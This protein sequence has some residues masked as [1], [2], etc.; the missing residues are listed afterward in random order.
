MLGLADGD[1]GGVVDGSAGLDALSPRDRDAAGEDEGFGPGARLGE[2]ALDEE[3]V[4][5]LFLQIVTIT[6]RTSPP[7]RASRKASAASASGTRCV[8]RPAART[9]PRSMSASASR[10][11]R[12]VEE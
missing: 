11:S 10:R 8:T 6:F 1:L 9:T 12:S 4:E 2:A 7:P 3:D 5:P